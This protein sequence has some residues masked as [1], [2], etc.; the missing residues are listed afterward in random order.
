MDRSTGLSNQ[1]EKSV[2]EAFQKVDRRAKRS[3][4]KCSK[5]KPLSDFGLRVDKVKKKNN[6]VVSFSSLSSSDIRNRS[7]LLVK[8]AR[9]CMELGAK[10]KYLELEE[11]EVLD[12]ELGDFD[13]LEEGA[14]L[15]VEF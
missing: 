12:E 5:K 10:L 8:K 13:D 1:R 14:S 11:G 7:S 3:R 6:E 4:K 15:S 2:L 9:K